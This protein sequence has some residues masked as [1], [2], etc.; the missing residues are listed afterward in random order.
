MYY[1]YYTYKP[2]TAPKAIASLSIA[3]PPPPISI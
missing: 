3:T 2:S 1:T